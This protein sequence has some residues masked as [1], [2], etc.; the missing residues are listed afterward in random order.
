MVVSSIGKARVHVF[1]TRE[2]VK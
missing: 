2:N 1:G